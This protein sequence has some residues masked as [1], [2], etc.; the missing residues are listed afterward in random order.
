MGL[1]SK[2]GV[3]L[4]VTVF[5]IVLQRAGLLG[6][7]ADALIALGSDVFNWLVDQILSQVFAL[8]PVVI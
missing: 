8:A 6:E 7:F 4:V 2:I 3:S 5:V 1:A